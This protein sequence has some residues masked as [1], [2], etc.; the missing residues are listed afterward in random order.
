[1]FKYRAYSILMIAVIAAAVVSSCENKKLSYRE[2]RI[3]VAPYIRP[4]AFN[5]T[6]FSIDVEPD[7]SSRFNLDIVIYSYSQGKE[8]I[9]MKGDSGFVTE[10]GAAEI[11]ALVKILDGEKIVRAEFIEVSGNSN[12]ELIRNLADSVSAL[13][14][15]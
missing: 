13:R 5:L 1:M 6:G 3:S 9:S 7:P 8:T 11:K 15:Y 14:G 10:A 2:L 12:D 4:E